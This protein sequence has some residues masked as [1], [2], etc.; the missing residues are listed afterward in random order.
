MTIPQRAHQSPARS[1][2]SVEQ[3]GGRSGGRPVGRS[4]KAGMVL[5]VVAGVAWTSGMIW[6]IGGWVL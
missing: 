1:D 4:V 5:A 3:S 2:R 6:T